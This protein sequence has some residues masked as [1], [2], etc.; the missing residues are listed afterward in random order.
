[1]NCI[2]CGE[3]VSWTVRILSFFGPASLLY[4]YGKLLGSDPRYSPPDVWGCD[5]CKTAGLIEK[6]Q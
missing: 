4:H 3:P 2:Q 1:M 5:R 6:T